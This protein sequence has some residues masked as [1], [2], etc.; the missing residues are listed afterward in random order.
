MT[1]GGLYVIDGID[2]VATLAPGK[3]AWQ[4]EAAETS[5]TGTQLLDREQETIAVV[6]Y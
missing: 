3:D 1:T 6:D 5:M 4:F 2:V